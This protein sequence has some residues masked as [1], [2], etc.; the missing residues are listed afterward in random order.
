MIRKQL[1]LVAHATPALAIVWALACGA[2]EAPTPNANDQG[3]GPAAGGGGMGAAPVADPASSGQAPAV[4]PDPA[5]PP[6]AEPPAMAGD[7]TMPPAPGSDPPSTVTPSAPNDDII[8]DMEGDA[9]TRRAG[10]YPGDKVDMLF[11]VDNSISMGDKQALFVEAIP[12]LIDMLVNPPCLDKGVASD[13]EDDTIVPFE[14]DGSC[15][16]GVG[17]AFAAVT[18]MHIAVISSS[19]GNHGLGG[20]EICPDVPQQNDKAH[21]V[22][23]MRY[24]ENPNLLADSYQQLGF[25]AWAPD[26]ETA[27]RDTPE[28]QAAFAALQADLVAK[29]S[30]QVAAV[31][32]HGCGFEA[33]LEAAYRFLVEPEP[34]LTLERVSC[35]GGSDTNCVAPMGTDTELL[36]QRANFLRPDSH[37][38]VTYL[39]DEND[40]SVKDSGQGYY[41]LR[42]TS[43]MPRGTNACATDPNDTCCQSCAASIKDG[44]DADPATN[45][46]AEPNADQFE[47]TQ[48]QLSEAFNIRCYDQKRRFGMDFLYGTDRYLAGF[49]NKQLLTRN[50]EIVDNP[51]FAGGRDLTQVFVVGIV[52]TPW[53]DVSSDPNDPAGKVQRAAA[54]PWELF[55]P[56]ETSPVPTDPF[57]IETTNIRSGT[58]PITMEVLGGPDTSN[59]I[60]GFDRDIISGD[61]LLDDVQFACT[62]PLPTPRDCSA[63]DLDAISC[64]CTQTPSEADPSV[65]ID[66]ATNNPLCRSPE[67]TYGT[68][69]YFAKAYPAPR[70]L[71]V[72]RGMKDQGVLGSICP[73][74]AND[75]SRPDYGYRPPIRALLLG[76]AGVAA[77]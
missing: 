6:G 58:H 64:D 2:S 56:S 27:K 23:L 68:T 15:P 28:A 69:Q 7:P 76:L 72:V 45:G 50:N 60:N 40:C 18:D 35:S 39:T 75:P 44:C 61:G 11:V 52:G 24:D 4:N 66:Y 67:G 12:D 48:Q 51:L 71:E 25:L 41:T 34:Y 19:L 74:N 53:Q 29:F 77:R 26:K 38:V 30:A 9:P 14:A 33:P 31:G 36:N 32:E 57:N 16:E 46:C 63:A 59:G 22:S 17:T 49:K 3:V 70:M 37:V 54:L 1:S 42:P 47:L 20:N 55:L 62:Y 21:M 8:M 65:I 43:P 13:P 73:R 10:I 5:V